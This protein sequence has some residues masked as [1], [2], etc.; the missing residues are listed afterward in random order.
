MKNLYK[1]GFIFL[2]NRYEEWRD[3]YCVSRG[4]ISTKIIASPD[5]YRLSFELQDIGILEIATKFEFEFDNS[6]ILY[7][8]IQYL[9]SSNFNP[10]VPVICHL[11]C[12]NN[13][14][15]YVRFAMTNPDRIIEFYGRVLSVDEVPSNKSGK[16]IDESPIETIEKENELD[17]SGS[18]I[19]DIC[20][21][22]KKEVPEYGSSILVNCHPIIDSPFG[23]GG[24]VDMT[25][26]I[27]LLYP[28][29]EKNIQFLIKAQNNPDEY[30]EFFESAF[31]IK[32]IS[33]GN[34]FIH[35]SFFEKKSEYCTEGIAMDLGLSVLWADRNVG[36][37]SPSDYGIL[38]GY[39]DISGEMTTEDE[40]AYPSM[41]IVNTN[42]DIAKSIWGEDWRMP[43]TEELEELCK[44]C[45]WKDTCK[46]GI[47][48]CEVIGPN[49]NSIF[50]PF[51]GCR[52]GIDTFR[53]GQLGQIWA[54]NLSKFGSAVEMIFYSH[55]GSVNYGASAS[56]GNSVRPVKKK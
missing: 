30:F 41:D 22:E 17:G 18:N 36:A 43:T 49:G 44:E 38:Y 16:T 15:K 20:S 32:C 56:W 12:S 6:D 55:N 53:Q 23:F 35:R 40:D 45:H 26:S 24:C 37:S 25:K 54:G 33:I 29:N 48:G 51:A 46:D 31:I 7:D 42:S 14:I 10:L 50:L 21:I 9:T 3:G 5:T 2:A 27:K 13:T 11:F 39:G 8:R 1:K 4:P 34:C 28:D 19:V 52:I 47:N